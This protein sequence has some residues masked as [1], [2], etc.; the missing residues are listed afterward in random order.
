[1]RICE[2]EQQSGLRILAEGTGFFLYRSLSFYL[3]IQLSSGGVKEVP[4]SLGFK[5][6][7]PCLQNEAFYN[8]A[9]VFAQV[10]GP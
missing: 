6:C 10:S 7:L 5:A 8:T 1:M 9:Q 4:R 2:C 3:Q